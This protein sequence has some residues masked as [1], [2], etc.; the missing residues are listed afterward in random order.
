MPHRLA[1]LRATFV[2]RTAT[3]YPPNHAR[4]RKGTSMPTRRTF[5]RLALAAACGTLLQFATCAAIVQQALIAGLINATTN[6]LVDPVADAAAD[7]A[8]DALEP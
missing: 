4:E 2:T 6:V 5:R 7:A 3:R 1:S 8:R